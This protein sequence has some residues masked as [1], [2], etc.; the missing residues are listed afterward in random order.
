MKKKTVRRLEY[1]L[2]I[3]TALIL[4]LKGSFEVSKGLLFPAFIITVPALTVLAILLLWRKLKITP[5]HAR[6]VCYYIE[7]PALLVSAYVL[8]LEGKELQPYFF[9]LA[10]LLY[11]VVGFISTKKFKKIQKPHQSGA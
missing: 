2:H 1:F 6:I 4:L 3:L 5:K 11:P 9:F 8:H 7:T 10:A